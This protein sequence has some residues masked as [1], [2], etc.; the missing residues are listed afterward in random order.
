MR[1]TIYKCN[2]ELNRL[3][4]T[5]YLSNQ[6]TLEGNVRES[7]DHMNVSI[8]LTY[9]GGLNGYNYIYIED[10]NRYYF[11]NE[12]TIIR[13][14]VHKFDLSTDV[15]MSHKSD[16]LNCGGIVSRNEHLYNTF[17][18]DDQLRFLGYKEINTYPLPKGVKNGETFILAVNGGY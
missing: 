5:P 6:M 4:K 10:F 11:V 15:L 1:I 2:A 14:G 9:S 18:I 7:I 16:I 12:H 13:T 8:T 17:L 3:N